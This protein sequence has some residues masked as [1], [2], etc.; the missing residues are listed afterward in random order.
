MSKDKALIDI[1]GG[2]RLERG[3]QAIGMPVIGVWP[4]KDEGLLGSDTEG[5]GRV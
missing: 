4:G 2:V 3:T 5:G 1:E